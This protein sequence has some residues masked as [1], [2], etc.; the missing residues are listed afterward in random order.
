MSKRILFIGGVDHHL[1]LPFF[2]ALKARGFHP[3]AAS[4]GE[5]APFERAG[6]EHR[7]LSFDRFLSPLSDLQAIA[8]IRALIMS[9]HPDIVQ[10][11][12]SKLN[13]LVAMANLRPP[14]FRM[15]RT[16]NGLGWL[17]ASR[18]PMAVAL[19]PVY[20]GL[21]LMA[22]RVVGLTLFENRED[23][24]AFER[25]G[26]MRPGSGRLVPGAG[27]D[28]RGFEESAVA[29][30]SRFELRRDLGLEDREIIVTVTRVTREKGIPTLLKAARLVHEARP[31]VCF[32]LV[33]PR[34]TEGP[35]AVTE[36]ELDRYKPYVVATGWRSDIAS[37]L[38]A[39][40]ICAFP[41]EYR[42]GVPRAILEAAVANLP[43]VTT[44]VPGCRDVVRD[45]W[46]GYVA[47]ER[48]PRALADKILAALG[49]PVAARAMARRAR[50]LVT[51]EYELGVALDR[52]VEAYDELLN[53]EP[54]IAEPRP[55]PI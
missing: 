29:G 48:D 14:R 51:R 8:A 7:G 37:L 20:R 30:P 11:F 10:T 47:P 33:G 31:S 39:A 50:D 15:I 1:R 40:D 55:H 35:S 6:I 36:A 38:S 41:T 45:G 4:S 24:A 32:L 28:V 26:L 2:V 16:I 25:W 23:Q 9:E 44:D 21:H 5:A 12:D 27:L 49:D 46:S 13:L 18:S 54:A 34:E 17:Y 42:E 53:A 3:I 22:S 19:R 43:I 52:Y